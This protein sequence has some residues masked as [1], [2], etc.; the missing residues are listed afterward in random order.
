M[1]AG[2]ECPTIE[3]NAGRAKVHL[4]FPSMFLL[5]S[6]V[7]LHEAV[8]VASRCLA[9]LFL[10][11]QSVPR[12]ARKAH[13]RRMLPGRTIIISGTRY[14]PT[15]FL[16]MT[17]V[18]MVIVHVRTPPGYRYCAESIKQWRSLLLLRKISSDT[19]R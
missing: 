5:M 9:Y 1:M 3:T 18:V 13:V 6:K 12:I 15:F 8:T 11:V 10:V 14:S 2:V 7:P 4:V 17:R 19:T 16:V